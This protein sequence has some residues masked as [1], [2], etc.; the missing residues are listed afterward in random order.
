VKI[1]KRDRVRVYQI[2]QKLEMLGLVRADFGRPA[3]YSAMTPETAIERLVSIHEAKLSL[4][5]SYQTELQDALSRAEPIE[6]LAH[7]GGGGEQNKPAISMFHGISGIQHL[8]RDSVVG[9]SVDIVA[10]PDSIE[11]IFSTIERAPQKPDS[12]KVLISGNRADSP[13]RPILDGTLGPDFETAYLEGHLPTFILTDNQVLIL[14]YSIE[15]Y[16]PKPLSSAR[17][18]LLMLHA[19]VVSDRSYVEEM[20]QLFQTLWHASIKVSVE[21]TLKE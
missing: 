15:K 3:G 19:L 16:R 2:L 17:S 7:H 5:S 11:Y 18:R 12:C 4:L 6:A 14:F 1:A 20:R 8:I 10:N 9:N 13:I 21:P